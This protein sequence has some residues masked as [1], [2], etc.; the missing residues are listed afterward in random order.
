MPHLSAVG[1]PGLLAGE[2]VNWVPY[3][4]KRFLLFSRPL[5]VRAVPLSEFFGGRQQSQFAPAVSSYSNHHS[6]THHLGRLGSRDSRLDGPILSSQRPNSRHTRTQT[7]QLLIGIAD[8]M[9]HDAHVR[10]TWASSNSTLEAHGQRDRLLTAGV[11][12]AHLVELQR[13]CSHAAS[14]R[15]VPERTAQLPVRRLIQNILLE[16]I[17][18]CWKREFSLMPGGYTD[19]IA[20]YAT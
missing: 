14:N 20:R 8:P 6:G 5:E 18:H 19:C 9:K 17:V 10:Y 7:S 11:L 2:D 15:L 13:I 16:L 12:L 3:P 4:S 1:I